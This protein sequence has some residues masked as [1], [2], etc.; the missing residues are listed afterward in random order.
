[1]TTLFELLAKKTRFNTPKGQLSMEQVFDLPLRGTNGQFDLNQLA[2][3]LVDEVKEKEGKIDWV[4]K[5]TEGM[6]FRV[7]ANLVTTEY[8]S[9]ANYRMVNQTSEEEQSLMDAREKH[10]FVIN[11]IRFKVSEEQA[12]VKDATAQIEY[13]NLKAE[14]ARRKASSVSTMSEEDIIKRMNELSGI[15][16]PA[17]E[18]TEAPTQ[19]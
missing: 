11:V 13:A 4:S 6:G 12:R 18:A 17:Q 2:Q 19:G 10:E 16:Q 5:A 15:E 3:L 8:Q 7:P 1:M 14:L 9:Y